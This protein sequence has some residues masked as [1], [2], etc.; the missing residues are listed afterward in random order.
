MTSEFVLAA[1][2][3]VN[4]RRDRRLP[5]RQGGRRDAY[6]ELLIALMC[7]AKTHTT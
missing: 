2:I 1:S 6:S 4:P 3:H 5:V 7:Q